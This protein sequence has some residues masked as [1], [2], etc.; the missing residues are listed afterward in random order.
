[1]SYVHKILIITLLQYSLAAQD[2][3]ITVF[4]EENITCSIPQQEKYTWYSYGMESYGLSYKK[5]DEQ[6]KNCRVPSDGGIFACEPQNENSVQTT[7]ESTCNSCKIFIV[8]SLKD[9]P[10][11][12]ANENDKNII[13]GIGQNVNFSCQINITSSFILFWIAVY[14]KRIQCLL[15]AEM[16]RNIENNFTAAFNKLCYPT[17]DIRERVNFSSSSNYFDKPQYLNLTIS[18]I[19]AIDNG[20]YLCI[21]YLWKNGG[22]KWEIANNQS[23][24]VTG[25]QDGKPVTDSSMY[26][27]AGTIGGVVASVGSLFLI[28]FCIRTKGKQVQANQSPPNAVEPTDDYECTPYAVSERREENPR[29]LYA[30]AQSPKLASEYSEV[31]LKSLVAPR[32]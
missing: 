30:L 7:I 18:S 27:A 12:K 24:Q 15:S 1:M 5:T 22:H 9:K 4:N 13:K 26:I 2:N 10:E 20:H 28:I 6:G 11:H 32:D 16:D 3:V 19:A 29:I 21:I 31:E 25:N 14:P 8:P 17:A 23:L